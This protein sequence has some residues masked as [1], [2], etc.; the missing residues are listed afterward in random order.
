LKQNTVAYT[1]LISPVLATLAAC[2]GSDTP[3]SKTGLN[4]QSDNY[5]YTYS[6]SINGV[7][8]TTGE[9]KYDSKEDY[10]AGLKDEKLN[11]GCAKETRK[12]SFLAESCPGTFGPTEKPKP[13]ATPVATPKYPTNPSPAPSDPLPPEEVARREAFAKSE[14]NGRQVWALTDA[15]VEVVT[16]DVLGRNPK[17]RVE[18][19]CSSDIPLRVYGKY[20][21]VSL[22]IGTLECDKPE[23]ERPQALRMMGLVASQLFY[24][25]VHIPTEEEPLQFQLRLQHAVIAPQLNIREQRSMNAVAHAKSLFFDFLASARVLS[26]SPE[27]TYY[28]DAA[29]LTP[30]Q[31]QPNPKSFKA[32][33]RMTNSKEDVTV[34]IEGPLNRV[35][36]EEAVTEDTSTE[37]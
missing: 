27:T 13:S 14:L 3:G 4:I 12:Q 29:L 5:T 2:G 28:F 22:Q 26:S 37:P 31:T 25:V 20:P 33:F 21:E 11:N 19:R 15:K 34:S 30:E 9:R 17:T 8:C 6:E 35:T 23:A 10:C 18:M 1:A 16:E 7:E 24:R 36:D 32:T